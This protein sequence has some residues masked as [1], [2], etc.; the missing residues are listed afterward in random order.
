MAVPFEKNN[1]VSSRQLL[2][3]IDQ[4]ALSTVVISRLG[5]LIGSFRAPRFW[6]FVGGVA[7]CSSVL[8]TIQT[9]YCRQVLC[10]YVLKRKSNNTL[11]SDG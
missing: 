4:H 5:H 8:N 9:L 2:P 6:G 3:K 11:K 7:T 1:D 10:R